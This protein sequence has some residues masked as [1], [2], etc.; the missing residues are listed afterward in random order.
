M[1]TVPFL[2]T[3]KIVVPCHVGNCIG[4]WVCCML[5]DLTGRSTCSSWKRRTQILAGIRD[6]QWRSPMPPVTRPAQVQQARDMRKASINRITKET[7]V[8]IALD[9]DGTGAASIETGIG[10]LDHMLDLFAR[11]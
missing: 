2:R 7:D 9:L 5:G 8:R 3:V 10:F 4:S 1:A 6:P 11:H